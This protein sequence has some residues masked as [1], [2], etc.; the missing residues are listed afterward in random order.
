MCVLIREGVEKIKACSSD[1]E[2]GTYR[3]PTLNVSLQSFPE[4]MMSRWALAGHTC[5]HR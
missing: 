1:Q 3:N 4:T 5:Q 2:M